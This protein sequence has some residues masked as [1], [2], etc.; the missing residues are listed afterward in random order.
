MVW[1]RVLFTIAV[2]AGVT[3]QNDVRVC[4]PK[5]FAPY[6][7]SL[8]SLGSPVVCDGV[9]SSVDCLTRLNRGASDF[10]VF[11]DEDMVLMAHKQPDRN[12]VVASVRDVL[13]KDAYAF[14]AVAVVPASHAGGLEGLRGMKYCHPGL[15]DSEPSW[16]PRVQK[17]LERAA[18]KIDSCPDA[19][20]EVQ[21]LS[22]FFHSACRPGPWSDD[23]NVDAD[24]K[25]RFSN[26]CALCGQNA[27]CSKYTI[28]MGP[29]INNVDNNNRH[30]QALECMRSNGNNT[31]VYAAWQHVRTYFNIRN[32]RIRASYSLLCEDGSLRPLTLEATISDVSPCSFV[33]QPWG[34]IVASSPRANQASSAIKSWWPSGSNPGGNTW[35]SVLYTALIGSFPNVVYFEDGLPTPGSYIQSGNF[36]SIDDSS[37]CI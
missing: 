2:A 22:S 16:S 11:S 36:T 19:E 33:K 3:A 28:N 18:A 7:D 26:L 14:E 25:S 4:V 23:D 9:E 21:T 6:C 13:R 20:M 29:N 5:L 17:T 27:K 10:G 8:Q 1:Q 37:S 35:Q 15:D 34:A 32:P 31:F 24:L 30:I 12:R